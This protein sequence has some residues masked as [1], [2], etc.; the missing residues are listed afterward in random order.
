[1]SKKIKIVQFKELLSHAELVRSARKSI[2]FA[3][4]IFQKDRIKLPGINNYLKEI[5]EKG[6]ALQESENMLAELVGFNQAL[7]DVSPIGIVSFD[8]ISGK[9]LSANDATAKMMGT[10]RE[11]ILKL[12][13]KEI[14]SLKETDFL[15]DAEATL[16][17]EKVPH[18]EIN[19]TTSLGKNIWIDYR[20]VKFLDKASPNLLLMINDITERRQSEAALRESE[21]NLQTIFENTSDGFVLTDNKGIVKSVNKKSKEIIFLNVGKLIDIGDSI[22]EFVQ[23]SKI[24]DYKNAIALVLSGQVLQYDYPYERKNGETK[25]YYY[26]VSPVYHEGL[27]DGICITTADVTARKNSEQELKESELFN[28]GILASLSAHI[29]VLNADGLIISVNKAWDE[30]ANANGSTSLERVSQGSNYFD[31]CKKSLASGEINAGLALDGILA[32]QQ[33]EKPIF[34]LEYP[35]HSPNEERW[36][37]L[38]VTKFGTDDSKVVISHHDITARK[39][40]EELVIVSQSNLKA[41]IE[42]TNAAIYSLDKE[43]RYIT[44]N[45]SHQAIMK[46]LYGLKISPGDHVYDFLKKLDKVEAVEWQKIYSRAL[47]GE[48]VLFEKE[49]KFNNSYSCIS[50]SIHPIWE[51]SEVIGLSCFAIDVTERKLSDTRLKELNERIQKDA[52]VLAISNEELEQFAHV[53]SHD[54]QEPLRMVTS[55]L[56]LLEKKYGAVIDEKGKTYIG[57]AVDGALRMRQIILDLLEYS[58]VGKPGENPEQIDL[59]ELLEEVQIL[60]RK[61]I[62]EIKAIIIVDKLPQLQAQRSPMRQIFQN[63]VGNALKYCSNIAPPQIHINAKELKDHWEF[64]VAD[65]GIGIDKEYFDKI[66]IIFQRLHRKEEYVGTG[67]GLAVTKKNVEHMGGRI[68]VES[69]EGKGS[70]FYFTLPKSWF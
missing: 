6:D 60:F 56:T 34:E 38:R 17:G 5:K 25:W 9:C 19:L 7:I 20:F 11:E 65:N 10:S 39:K 33:K 69:K 32:V 46:E 50:F 30:F 55:F 16:R 35:C 12:N 57:F 58:K 2:S 42:N 15:N 67:M 14:I 31:V 64:S 70:T 22:F 43:L 51:F 45:L 48:M 26:T 23:E 8:G 62:K 36:F 29:A 28:K 27:I 3:L 13:F 41:I 59:N 49:F 66:F 61:K 68:W 18:K 40:A 21:A 63:L 4:E 53:V 47:K 54:L 24:E 52:K 1:M 37:V 44:F